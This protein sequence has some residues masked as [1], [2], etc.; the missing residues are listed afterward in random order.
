M[1]DELI[2]VEEL[3]KGNISAAANNGWLSLTVP[4]SESNKK[5]NPP[6]YL[7]STSL[8][9]F[10]YPSHKKK[11]ILHD[12]DGFIVYYLDNHSTTEPKP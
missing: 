5:K 3:D 10:F 11:G 2:E 7:F 1:V 6:P 12:I 8:P 4:H 9:H